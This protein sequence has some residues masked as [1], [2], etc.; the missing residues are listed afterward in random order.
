MKQTFLLFAIL[1][2][3]AM[4]V[5]AQNAKLEQ[6]TKT[7]ENSLMPPVPVEG[8]PGWNILDR[9][10]DYKVPGVSIAVIKDYK[11]DWAKAY[12]L[13]DT[14]KKT[15]V[16]T[17]TMFSAGSV[18]KLVMAAAALRLV[19]EGKLTLDEPINNYLTSWKLAEN[20]WTRQK[21]VTLRMLLSHTGG[22][23]QS[24]YFGYTP[25]KNPLPTLVEILSG[26]PV[27]EANPVVVN[28][29]PGKGFRYSGGGSMVAQLALMDV[30]KKDFAT[31]AQDMVF[32]PLGMKNATFAQPLPGRFAAQASWGY[33][34]ASWYKGMPYVYPQQAAAGLYTTATDLAKF[35]IDIQKSYLGKGKTLSVAMTRQMMTPQAV[36]SEGENTKEQIAVGPFL[37]QRAGNKD[38]R[39]VYFY[40]DGT[41]AGFT[42]FTQA[43]VEGG[44][45]VVVLLNSG[46]DFNGLGKEI[47]RAVAQTYH[48][49][50]FLPPTLQPVALDTKELDKYTGR[51]RRGADE[52]VYIRREKGYLVE[53]INEG[54]DI[55]CFP[56]AK[57]TIVFTDFNIK[58]QFGR[59]AAGDVVSLRSV[60]QDK[61]MPKMKDNEFSPSEHLKARRYA[62]AKAGFR[63]MNLN[64]Y[65]VTYLAYE[66]S[67][68]KPN[69]LNAVKAILELALEQHPKSA[70]VHS[71][72]GDYCLKRNEPAKAVEYYKKALELDPTDEQTRETLKRLAK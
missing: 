12:G 22:T 35:F 8:F 53:K 41:N 57:D 38:S 33:S 20:D 26:A 24:A 61:P 55:Y 5:S 6:R 18:S 44:N 11:I 25:D 70:I 40:F 49:H 39:G 34:S 47:I 51:Y 1:S 10:K 59:D 64:E 21:P 60:Y 37:L 19:Q 28:S 71:R 63:Q 7:V 31:L 15:P 69:D 17:E 3:F 42:A 43:S 48:W 58:G 54:G 66:L 14:T 16:T 45:G 30:T 67:N 2:F 27:A 29:E 52:V 56:V 65:Q 23:S 36:F 4:T 68:K 62:E 46:D 50:N 72:W 9:M 32:G 13:A